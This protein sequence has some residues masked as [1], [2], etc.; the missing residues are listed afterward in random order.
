M[1]TCWSLQTWYWQ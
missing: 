1:S